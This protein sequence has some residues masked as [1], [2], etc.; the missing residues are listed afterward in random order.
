MQV[1]KSRGNILMNEAMINLIVDEKITPAQA[2][3][4]AVDKADLLPRFDK[5]EIEFDPKS[6]LG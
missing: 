5:L 6:V 3:L 1:A 2:Y 4:K